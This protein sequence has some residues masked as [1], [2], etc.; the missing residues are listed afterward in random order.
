MSQ[1]KDQWGLASK[2]LSTDHL[3]I[4]AEGHVTITP[5]GL[6][7]DVYKLAK[8]YGT[9]LEILLPGI[10]TERA[11]YLRSCFSNAIAFAGYTGTYS[12]C[13]PLK[14]NPLPDVVRAAVAGGTSVEVGTNGEAF[15]AERMYHHGE[16]AR[17]AVVICNGAK[18]QNYLRRI[19]EL[20]KNG[21][22]TI[23]IIEAEQEYFLI[24]DLM[25]KLN[26]DHVKTGL[27][28][29]TGIDLM[30]ATRWNSAT[31]QNPFGLKT[32]DALRFVEDYIAKDSAV[33]VEVLHSHA[34]SQI[35][36][37]EAMVSAIGAVSEVY[38]KLRQRIDALKFIDV[39][40]GLPV[41]YNKKPLFSVSDYANRAVQVIKEK[42]NGAG[43]P[44]PNIIVEAGRWTCA[45]AQFTVFGTHYPKPVVDGLRFIRIDG[46]L[47]TDLPDTW[48][49]S[50]EFLV[51]PVNGAHLPALNKYWLAGMTCDSDDVYPSK[52]HTGKA[53]ESLPVVLLPDVDE[54]C[55]WKENGE[56]AY[57]GVLATGA[58]Q[59][60]L[61]GMK[62]VKHCLV[63]EA[64]KIR[65][66]PDGTIKV[67]VERPTP[68]DVAERLNWKFNNS[69]K[70]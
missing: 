52:D 45:P 63:P 8:Q 3:E 28:V 15:I 66:E 31:E 62:G 49:V 21:F 48:G 40:G 61:S 11:Q 34:G 5:N 14:S 36:D 7:I 58:Y 12:H 46:S 18:E 26:M 57:I 47:M 1:D 53:M 13:F 64:K 55:R 16:L 35:E 25:G 44:D 17:D 69:N 50:Q 29:R 56:K 9:P 10:I 59:D 68:S 4:N 70:N 30:G 2:S 37:L 19:L 33:Q 39:G 67:I 6:R 41:A 32:N 27:R 51:V 60:S 24:K 23:P 22:N 38:V 65:I 20:Q 42:C 54:Q 43:L